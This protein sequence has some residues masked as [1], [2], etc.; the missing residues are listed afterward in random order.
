MG[1]IMG[2]FAVDAIRLG[3]VFLASCGGMIV[4]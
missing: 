4:P 1:G 3:R 2:R